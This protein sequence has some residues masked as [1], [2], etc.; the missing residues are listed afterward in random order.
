MTLGSC[1]AILYL[2][3]SHIVK[4]SG[5]CISLRVSICATRWNATRMRRTKSKRGWASWRRSGGT[6]LRK[7]TTCLRADSVDG[8]VIFNIRRSRYR[9]ITVVHYSRTTDEKETEGHVYIRS[10]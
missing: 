1:Q 8:Y 5:G 9:L 10:F 2:T 7:S 4:Y 6:I 3:T